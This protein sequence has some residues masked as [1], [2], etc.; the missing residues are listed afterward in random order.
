MAGV[1]WESEDTGV[2]AGCTLRLYFSLMAVF[3]HVG[4]P[5]AA[6]SLAPGALHPQLPGAGAA[7]ARHWRWR[8]PATLPPSVLATALALHPKRLR[9]SHL[10]PG[11][12]LGNLKAQQL[13]SP[14]GRRLHTPTRPRPPNLHRVRK[15]GTLQGPAPWLWDPQAF[16]P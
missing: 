8:G 3:G 1:Y 9:L 2:G 13:H 10:G 15:G 7:P 5:G 16:L 14:Q 11:P 12:L 6:A 4:P